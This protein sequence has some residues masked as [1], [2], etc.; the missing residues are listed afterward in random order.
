MIEA[1]MEKLLL[2]KLHGMAE[3]LREQM[4]NP[5]Y[6]DLSFEERLALLV[7]KEKLYRENRQLKTLASQVHF[8]HPSACFV[9]PEH[10]FHSERKS[11]R[12]RSEL[13]FGCHRNG[14]SVKTGNGVRG[15]VEFA[16]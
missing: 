8:R 12:A 5:E 15:G 1:T 4:N 9:L 2:M 6:K 10:R 3:G 13:P 11:V 7:D 14:C 16:P